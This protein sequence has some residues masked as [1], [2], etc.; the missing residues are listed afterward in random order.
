M[1]DGDQYSKDVSI[2]WAAYKSGSFP[3]PEDL[4][5][6][7]FIDNLE[8]ALTQFSATWVVDDDS[9]VFSSKRGPVGM[10]SVSTVGLIVEPRFVFFKWATKRNMLRLV[11]SFI[12]MIRHSKRTG[13]IL[14]RVPQAHKSMPDHLKKYDMLHFIGKSAPNEYLFSVRGRGSDAG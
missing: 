7:E 4:G 9:S 14:V 3:L 13:L 6:G 10:V 12:N 8:Q 2:L 1:L 11:V 5:Q